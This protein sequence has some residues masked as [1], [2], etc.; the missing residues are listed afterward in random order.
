MFELVYTVGAV[1]ELEELRAFD[2]ARLLDAIADGLARDPLTMSRRKKRLDLDG[3]TSVFQLRVGEYRVF[4]DVELTELRVIVLHVR[5][6]GR[7]TTGEV[8]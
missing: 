4:Y 6:K 8:L 7:R 5:R 1:E 3:G 2:R